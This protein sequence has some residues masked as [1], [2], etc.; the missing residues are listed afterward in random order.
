MILL[1]AA[2]VR[3]HLA[4]DGRR[5]QRRAALR[6]A[7]GLVFGFCGM[8]V[9]SVR[10][11]AQNSAG[12]APETPGEAAVRQLS[13][14]EYSSAA[15][16][17]RKAMETAPDDTVLNITAGAVA[18][19]TGD[20]E[21]ARTA[22]EHALRTDANDSL[23]LYG[24]GLARLAKGDRSGALSSFDRSEA[25]GGDRTYLLVARRYTQWLSGAQVDLAG[26]ADPPSLR[27]HRTLSWPCS[28][29]ERPSGR[30][31]RRRWRPPWA[32]FPAIRCWNPA[33][34]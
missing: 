15:Q 16:H 28:A 11:L 19:C 26:A 7:A 8:L 3:K 1:S 10:L 30:K 18:M 12:A 22:F 2:E 5:G 27:R 14:G 23:A 4:V 20:A 31:P 9:G 21:T 34:S 17:L 13:E 25:T 32:R 6:I 29:D 33:G 24:Q